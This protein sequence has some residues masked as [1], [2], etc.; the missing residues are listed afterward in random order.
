MVSCRSVVVGDLRLCRHR[1]ATR[2]ELALSRGGLSGLVHSH[3]AEM[4]RQRQMAPEERGLGLRV[5]RPRV[6]RGAHDFAVGKP[7]D[8]DWAI[9]S[10]EESG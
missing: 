7:V 5:A 4:K 10:L 9:E 1:V 8:G 6:L 3:V 2:P